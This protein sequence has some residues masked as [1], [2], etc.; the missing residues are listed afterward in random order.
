MRIRRT[1]AVLATLVVLAA[2][3]AAEPQGP[4]LGNLTY[5]ADEVWQP[6]STLPQVR[7]RGYTWPSWPMAT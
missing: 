4:G 6:I 5:R 1:T 3:S 2:A 7:T